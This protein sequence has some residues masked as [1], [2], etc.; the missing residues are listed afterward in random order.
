MSKHIKAFTY[1]PKI[2]D[3]ICGNC[4]QTIRPEGK[5]PVEVGDII[6]FHGW[7]GKPY[8]SKWSWRLEVTINYVNRC[9]IDDEGI[10]CWWMGVFHKSWWESKTVDKLAKLDGF[11]PAEGV[12]LKKVLLGMHNLDGQTPFQIIRWDPLLNKGGERAKE[13][14]SNPVEIGEKVVYLKTSAESHFVFPEVVKVVNTFRRGNGYLAYLVED[15]DEKRYNL[16]PEQVL[17]SSQL[18]VYQNLL[19]KSGCEEE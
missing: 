16:E 17:D 7:E 1:E 9:W 3:V 10:S 18:Q 14:M 6:I 19:K 15:I 5:N 13:K 12:E 8:R 11:S 4:V 2:P